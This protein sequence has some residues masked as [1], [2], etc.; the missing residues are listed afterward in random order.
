M[1]VYG[2]SDHTYDNDVFF[3]I[4]TDI[5]SIVHHQMGNIYCISRNL[6]LGMDIALR[7]ALGAI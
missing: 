7:F 1:S 2:F 5:G 6:K 3:F 4:K